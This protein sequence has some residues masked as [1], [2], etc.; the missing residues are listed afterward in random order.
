[1]RGRLIFKFS[2][3]LHRLDAEQVARADPDG[4]GPLQ[5]GYD[6]DFHEP[7]RVD[8]DQDGVGDPIRLEHRPVRVPCQV[9]PEVLDELRML[10]A[11]NSPTRQRELV[12]HFR[13]LERLGLVDVDTGVP[14]VQ[15]GDRLGALYDRRGELVQSFTNP[16]GLFVTKTKSTGYG[17][18][19]ARPRRNLL[20]VTFAD[21]QQA[22][23]RR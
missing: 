8:A 19:R 5:S 21:R 15:P 18:N 10:P 7:V 22:G 23:R 1:M 12:F 14:L 2:A 6:P 4:P 11:G 9:E 3:E 20:L 13:D 16:P 17:L